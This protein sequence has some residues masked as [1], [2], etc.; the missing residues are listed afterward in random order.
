[1]CIF[2]LFLIDDEL[3]LPAGCMT[4]GEL[5]DEQINKR[6]SAISKKAPIK[7]NAGI[8]GSREFIGRVE[9]SKSSALRLSYLCFLA[10]IFLEYAPISPFAEPGLFLRFFARQL[11][12]LSSTGITLQI[13]ETVL[14]KLTK[15]GAFLRC[16]EKESDTYNNVII[17]LEAV[18]KAASMTGEP[19]SLLSQIVSPRILA[20]CSNISAMSID[21]SDATMSGNVDLSSLLS[22][23]ALE[24]AFK[25]FF[26]SF[27]SLGDINNNSSTVGYA[28]VLKY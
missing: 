10:D 24:S 26:S 19:H 23:P 7:L 28:C 9:C 3:F 4:I 1:M 2:F 22:D 25:N 6:L 11:V 18:L 15:A 14:A 21:E 16:C 17:L 20:Q 13:Y 12:F 27:S 8:V 5:S